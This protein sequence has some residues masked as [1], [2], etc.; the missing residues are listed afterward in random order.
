MN[1][2]VDNLG[3][4]VKNWWITLLLGILFI[5]GGIG[6]MLTPL[7]SYIALS[8]VFSVL[9]IIGG[10]M[11][12]AFSVSNKSRIGG[13][14]WFLAAGVIDLVIGIYLIANP[15]VALA[16]LPYVLAFW[17]LFRGISIIGS[18]LDLKKSRLGN[19][20]WFMFFGILAIL[21]AFY[22]FWYPAVGAFSIVWFVSFALIFI[23]ITRIMIA[24]ELRKIK[25]YYK[26]GR[27][28][29]VP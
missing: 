27:E 4:V 1:T 24:F 18:S 5:L 3:Y 2:V 13:W 21:C 7:A 6:I 26:N 20:G 12:I 29:L 8:I 11:E 14:G 25:K 16:V 23:G 9:L 19:W 17:L 22:I 28:T 15:A 10:V